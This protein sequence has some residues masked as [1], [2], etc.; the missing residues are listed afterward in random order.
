VIR[1]ND[2]ELGRILD[3]VNADPQLK[4]T[5]SILVLPEF[6]RDKNLNQRNGLDHGDGS[7]ELQKIACVAAGPDIKM[8]GKVVDADCASVDVC[9]TVCK[10][11][12]VDAS[13]ARGKVLPRIF[14]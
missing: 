2:Q 1:R 7:P 12:G 5:T 8:A 9:P 11:L 14:S 10:L 4:E 3:I 13:L 6:G